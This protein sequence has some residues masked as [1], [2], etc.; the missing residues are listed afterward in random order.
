MEK[1]ISE[2]SNERLDK[3]L[4]N[5]FDYS[6]E[7]IIK[8]IKEEQVLVNGKVV[9]PSYKLN[10]DDEIRILSA[11]VAEEMVLTPV[12]MDLNIIFEDESII[13]LNKPTGL[14]VH[15]A[16]GHRDNTL[17][18]GLIHHSNELSN[19]NEGFRP[20]IV[21][22]LDKDTSGL[23]VVAKTNPVH[24]KLQEA[25]KNRTMKRSYIALCEGIIEEDTGRIKAPIGRDKKNRLKQGIDATGKHAIT[26]FEVVG[27]LRS[28]TILKCFL[29]TG[30][31]H[32][33]RVHLEYI[34]HPIVNDPL[35]NT[36]PNDHYGQYLHAYKL[37]FSHPITDELMSFISEVPEEFLNKVKELGGEQIEY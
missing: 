10:L 12:P 15:P 20:G 29:E 19:V 11:P 8:L 21:H 14:V 27:R 4:A 1:L 32:Q 13:V 23:M 17:V 2:V 9:K 7:I 22:R 3:Y 6:R 26:N 25:I 5:K 16:A 36:K 28:H 33:I 31:T 34:G 35:Y 30:R 18:N 24:L 37:E